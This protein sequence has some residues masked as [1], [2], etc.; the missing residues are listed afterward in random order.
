MAGIG[1]FDFG[2]NLRPVNFN[3]WLSTTNSKDATKLSFWVE[4]WVATYSHLSKQQ[5]EQVRLVF[6]ETLCEKPKQVLE[7]LV[8]FLEIEAKD[9]F[10]KQYSRI[11]LAKPHPVDN[12]EVDGEL[13]D[14]AYAL[15]EEMQTASLA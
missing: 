12:S 2:A 1:H 14:K 13:S 9:K 11:S 10:I 7:R 15:Y 5:G 3:A 4:Y 8:S 6:Y